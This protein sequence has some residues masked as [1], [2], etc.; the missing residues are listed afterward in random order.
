MLKQARCLGA[1]RRRTPRQPA[2]W[3]LPFAT[4]NGGDVIA[5]W[6]CGGVG[7]MAQQGANVWDIDAC[8]GNNYVAG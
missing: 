2:S 1:Q 7:L 5:V 8:V 6:G 4:Y 3:E